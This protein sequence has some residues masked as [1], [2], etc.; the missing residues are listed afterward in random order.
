MKAG[1][2][3]AQS[4]LTCRCIGGYV[5]LARPSAKCLPR[6]FY[7]WCANRYIIHTKSG[8]GSLDDLSGRTACKAEGTHQLCSALSPELRSTDASEMMLLVF[9]TSDV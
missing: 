3:L 6:R 4:A 2:E 8:F 1:G 9:F 5:A 7:S